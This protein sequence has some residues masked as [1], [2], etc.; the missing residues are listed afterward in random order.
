MSFLKNLWRRAS[1]TDYRNVGEACL[2]HGEYDV[3]N[4]GTLSR[5]TSGM[6]LTLRRDV[7]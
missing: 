4:R 2:A 3:L 7:S 5:F 6:V 1:A